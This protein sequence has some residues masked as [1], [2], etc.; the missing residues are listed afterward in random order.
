MVIG[1]LMVGAFACKV[2]DVDADIWWYL[3]LALSVWLMYTA[4][5]I[6]DALR[7]KTTSTIVRHQ[8]HYAHRRIIIPIWIIVALSSILLC[9]I[10]LEN[11]IIF[12]GLALGLCIMIYFAVIYFN[13]E[14]RPYFLQ[15]ELFIAIVYIT[16]IW[17]APMVWNS[18]LPS[19]II[20]TIVVNLVLLGWVE[21]IIISWFEFEEDTADNHVSFTV[22]FGRKNTLSF[23]I[24][25]LL[26]VLF[27]S[28]GGLMLATSLIIRT[29]FVI[30][31]LMVL[32]LAIIV[33]FPHKFEQHQLYR[34]MGEITFLFPGLILLV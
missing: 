7:G 34:Y 27:L 4:D 5:H 23:T 31:L 14:S 26:I 25:L 24:L 18:G 32:S 15:K 1:S 33:L 20:M 29:A 21:G 9:L 13:R 3:I 10:K 6:L 8:F 28:V 22:L 17:L 11:E 16:G 2:L 19:N 12:L 30:E